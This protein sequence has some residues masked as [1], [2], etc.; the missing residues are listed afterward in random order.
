LLWNYD[1]TLHSN[2]RIFIYLLLYRCHISSDWATARR[3]QVQLVINDIKV[4]DAGTLIQRLCFWTLSIILF[5]F[6]NISETAFC[7]WL[8]VKHTP[9][10][11]IDRASPYLWTP[12]QTPDRVYKPSTAKPSVRAKTK[13]TCGVFNILMF[14]LR[15]CRWFVLCLAC[16]PYLVLVQVSRDRD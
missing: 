6:K 11:L 16:I 3:G 10:D 15:S 1:T 12:V 7:L 2:T 4:C 8:E 13:H 5:L 14:C 9:L